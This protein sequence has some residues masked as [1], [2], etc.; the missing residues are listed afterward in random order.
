MS[1]TFPKIK[2][3]YSFEAA[4]VLFLY[5]GVLKTLPF[6]DSFNRNIDL[7]IVGA[8][9]GI[10]LIIGMLID[11][12]I[13]LYSQAMNYLGLYLVFLCWA[14]ITYGVSGTGEYAARKVEKLTIMTT[15]SVFGPLIIINTNERVERFLKLIVFMGLIAAGSGLMVG[16]VTKT[17]QLGTFGN[18]NYHP[19]GRTCSMGIIVLLS[20]F[21]FDT[22][23]RSRLLY[24]AALAILIPAMFLSGLRQAAVGLAVALLALPIAFSLNPRSSI[25]IRRFAVAML[26]AGVIVIGFQ[27]VYLSDSGSSGA[28]DRITNMVSI[29]QDG[30]WNPQEENRPKIMYAAWKLFEEYPVFGAGLGYYAIFVKMDTDGMGRWPHNLI[31]EILC[32]LGL[33]GFLLASLLFGLPIAT[34]LIGC[35]RGQD[36]VTIA[37]GCLWMSQFTCAM[38]SWDM[39]DNRM[40]FSLSAMIIA[41]H[42]FR[43]NT[44]LNWSTALSQNSITGRIA[45]GVNSR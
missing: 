31:L 12:K 45:G 22:R 36:H 32:E 41:N 25:Q 30:R 23:F 10:I 34:W 37:L 15:W 33:V 28:E 17:G 7:T 44:A 11:R 4:F 2:D 8:G 39:N 19:L 43:Q 24:A 42:A 20:F 27:K 3:F 5:A 6:F 26:C 38:F 13:T 29:G 40:I 21:I 1:P 14:L 18:E 35:R 9:F 16:S